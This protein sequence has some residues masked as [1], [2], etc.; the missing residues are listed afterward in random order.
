MLT[1][2]ARLVEECTASLEEYDYTRAL[3]RAESFF[4][5]FCD[6]YLE[7]V[8]SR[9]YGDLGPEGAASA[10][11]AMQVAL[12]TLLRLF[13]PYVPFVTEEVWSWWRDGS[14]HRATWPTA[15][16]VLAPLGAAD[17][18]GEQA[19]ELA[20]AVLGEIRRRKSE[21]Q[22]PMKTPVTSLVLRLPAAE[23]ALL[24]GVRADFSA[25][26]FVEAVVAEESAEREI[27][28]EFAPGEPVGKAQA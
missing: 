16:E 27:V 17:P 13:A 22:R 25:A 23:M 19:L 18:Q 8:K 4:W 10:N 20:T 12:S 14:V 7:L 15:T 6:N 24:E 1:R 28:V 3:D 5:G 26:G 11:H 9:R 2:L 21:Q